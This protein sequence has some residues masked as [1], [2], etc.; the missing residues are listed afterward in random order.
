[1]F[2]IGALYRSSHARDALIKE[3]LQL[4]RDD[5]LAI[6]LIQTVHAWAMRSNVGAPFVPNN[7][8]YFHRFSVK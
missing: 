7:L 2:N 4:V 3:A 6:R 5:L 1:M 8:P